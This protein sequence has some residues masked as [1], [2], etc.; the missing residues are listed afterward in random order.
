MINLTFITDNSLLSETAASAQLKNDDFWNKVRYS[1]AGSITHNLKFLDSRT[2]GYIFSPEQYDDS[3]A[4]LY[5]GSRNIKHGRRTGWSFNSSCM[6]I[7]KLLFT[8]FICHNK[9]QNLADDLLAQGKFT[10]MLID[11]GAPASQ[12]NETIEILRLHI[13]S[14]FPEEAVEPQILLPDGKA[15]YIAVTPV[16]SHLLQGELH[17]RLVGKHLNFIKTI[18]PIGNG[19]NVGTFGDLVA[20]SRGHIRILYSRVKNHFPF[21]QLCLWRLARDGHLFHNS[22]IALL[23]PA[24]RCF[25]KHENEEKSSY[26]NITDKEKAVIT[27]NSEISS[28][29]SDYRHLYHYLNK[30]P[31]RKN[32]FLEQLQTIVP[33]PSLAF[34]GISVLPSSETDTGSIVTEAW[35]HWKKNRFMTQTQFQVTDAYTTFIKNLFINTVSQYITEI[36]S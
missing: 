4:N 16:S 8:E 28:L 10:N 21:W 14:P 23:L 29:F 5:I 17:R 22:D 13:Q 2:H 20:D 35:E 19:P 6:K 30:Y 9:Q 31:D 1:V 18:L 32:V 3:S 33:T 34:L 27:L 36:F 26:Q 15:S 11:L 24:P 25:E 7:K 12:L